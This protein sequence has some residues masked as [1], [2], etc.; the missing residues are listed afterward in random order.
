MAGLLRLLRRVESRMEQVLLHLRKPDTQGLGGAGRN[1]PQMFRNESTSR[2]LLW[3]MRS[4][5]EVS[6]RRD[7]R[8]T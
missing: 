4:A 5:S 1:V 6:I 8:L 2:E 7:R 3:K